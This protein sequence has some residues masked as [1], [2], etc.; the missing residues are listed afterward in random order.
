MSTEEYLVA[1]YEI[2]DGASKYQLQLSGEVY[3]KHPFFIDFVKFDE[4]LAFYRAKA[5]S[6]GL[7]SN[8]EMLDFLIANGEW[9][10][11][12]EQ[13]IDTYK[14]QIENVEQTMA[15]LLIP[16]HIKRER[17]KIN[18]IKNKLSVLENSKDM[19]LGLT[20]EKFADSKVNE[21]FIYSCIFKDKTLLNPLIDHD[22]QF[23]IS[24]SRLNELV[25]AYLD[26]RK[27]FDEENL[28]KMCLQGFAKQYYSFVEN[29]FNMYGKP[30][31][32]MTTYQL[33]LIVFLKTFKSIFEYHD[34]IPESILDKPEAIF[35]FVRSKHERKKFEGKA[36]TSQHSGTVATTYF[37]ANKED[38]ASMGVD[39]S[40]VS[41]HD[42]L[43]RRGGSMSGDE[44]MK[45]INS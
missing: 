30:A 38:Y 19:I 44:F 43:R 20:I 28:Q 4:D 23:D 10:I 45:F 33:K 35:D 29:P 17:A 37:G 9:S 5:K 31:I 36:K 40:Y 25:A 12:Q 39:G 18:D 13:K 6:R 21:K 26:F 41:M 24:R 15:H 27:R 16:S 1:F 34:D 14:K 32:Q 2:A 8:K 42:E 22:E 11:E 7:L 3:I